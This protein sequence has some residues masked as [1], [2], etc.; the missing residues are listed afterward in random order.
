[1]LSATEDR[2]DLLEPL[3]PGLTYRK[4]EALYAVREEMAYTV[5]DVLDRRTRASLRD[6]RGAADAAR[7]VAELIGPELG[8][9]NDRIRREAESYADGVRSDL[10]RAGLDVPGYS[11]VT[12]NTAGGTVPAATAGGAAEPR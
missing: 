2:P 3:V 5:A 9:D 7:S 12:A 6:A 1:V 11:P 10:V 8:W 4:V